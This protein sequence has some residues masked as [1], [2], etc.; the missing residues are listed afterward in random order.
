TALRE[1]PVVAA[2]ESEHSARFREVMDDDF[3]TPEAIA[4]LQNMTREINSAKAAGQ[5]AKA[6]SLGAELRSLGS[7]LGL[8]Q[9]DPAQWARLFSAAFETGVGDDGTPEAAMSDGLI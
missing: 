7:V 9:V 1:L 8:A 4:V 3:N 5:S 6:A 2:V